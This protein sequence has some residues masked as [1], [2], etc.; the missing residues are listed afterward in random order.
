MVSNAARLAD[1]STGQPSRTAGLR[2]RPTQALLDHTPDLRG[3][4]AGVCLLR[5]QVAEQVLTRRVVL[6]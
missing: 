6:E 3:V 1:F 5:L 4:P 2:P